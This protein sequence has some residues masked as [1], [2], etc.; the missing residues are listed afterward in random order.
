MQ[1]EPA[2]LILHAASAANRVAD[3]RKDSGKKSIKNSL[4]GDWGKKKPISLSKD[5]LER[6]QAIK[7]VFGVPLENSV[8]NCHVETCPK[9]P[10]VVYRCIEFLELK[11][12]T[13]N[14][15]AYT[16]EGVYRLSGSSAIIQ[17]YRARFDEEGDI[18]L[19]ESDIFDI[20][21]V[22]GLLKLFLRELGDSI[23]SSPLKTGFL[24]LAGIFG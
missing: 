8:E 5:T 7:P 14:N 13:L 23:L 16:E 15:E 9:I 17:K 1:P 18:N 10:A 4:F 22:T 19:L 20:H 3:S 2:S 24:S 6:S 12:G 21:A 11:Q